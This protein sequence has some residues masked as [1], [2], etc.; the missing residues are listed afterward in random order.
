MPSLYLNICRIVSVCL[1]RAD[2]ILSCLERGGCSVLL[3][4]VPNHPILGRMEQSNIS[5]IY[6]DHHLLIVN[7]PA[8]LVVHPT[9]KYTE[10]TMWDILL[11]YLTGQDNNGWRPPDLAD[12]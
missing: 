11:A 6:Q 8:R 1:N 2:L 12:E 9:Y 3:T 4:L 10:G 5:I 7:K